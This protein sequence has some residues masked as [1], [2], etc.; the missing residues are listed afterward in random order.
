MDLAALQRGFGLPATPFGLAGCLIQP[1]EQ[2]T[3]GQPS[4]CIDYGSA[5]ALALGGLLQAVPLGVAALPPTAVAPPAVAAASA[6]A[7]A[8]A[9]VPSP[10]LDL[11]LAEAHEAYRAG[12]Y[13]RALALCAPVHAASPCRVDALLLLGAAHYQRGEYAACVAAND[14]AILLDPGLAEAHANLA[15]ALQQLGDMDTAIV[16]YRSALRLKPRFT[17][18]LNNMAS[19]LVAKGLVPAAM[20]AYGAALAI[21]P[22]LVDV[23]NNLGDLWRAQGA[24]GAAAARAR[25][26]EA[27]RLDPGY[28]PAWRGLGDLA[29]E[30]G[31]AAA[32]LGCY[33]E[34]AR[35]R[36]GYADALTGAGVALKELRRRSEAEACFEAAAALRPACA[37][38]LGNLGGMY[39]ERGKLEPAIAAYRRA[40]SLQPLFPEAYNNLGNALREA[41]RVGEAV[42]AYAACIRQQYARAGAP[43][44]PLPGPVAGRL[45]VAYANLG[46]LLKASGQAAPAI[47]CYEQVASLSPESPEAAANLG[48]AYKDAGQHDAAA[49]AYKRALALRPDFPEAFANLVHSLQCVCEWAERG[50]LFARL[51]GDVRRDL[52][53]GRLPAVQPFHA[54]A[55]PFPADLALAISRAYAGQAALAAARLALPPLPHPPAAP[56]ARGQRLRVAYVSADFGNHP[57]SHLM[58][59]VFGLHDRT[60]VEVFCYALSPPDGS[61]WRRRIEA[62]AEHFVDASG[63]GP[64]DIAR[65]ISADG[66]HVALNLN[67]Y[68]RGARNEVFALRPAPVQASYMGFPATTGAPYLPWLITDPVVAPPT[69]RHCYSEALALMP[70][71]YFVNDYARAHGDVLDKSTLPTRAEVGLPPGK[72]VYA[73]SNQLYKFDPDTFATWCR[74]LRRVPDR[75]TNPCPTSR[76]R[77]ANPPGPWP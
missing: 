36:P 75:C 70:H 31:D 44:A 51:E 65:R 15:N 46:G 67:G 10:E 54:M 58:G 76:D 12:D 62:E 21:N 53:G 40:L 38:S 48:S 61:E 26:A 71:C 4:V 13:T 50:P 42:E 17:D 14:A 39:Y 16:Y 55:Y 1:A 68:T 9:P 25:Y 19:A 43:G 66:V 33:G 29:R 37:L 5:H 74:I 20:E 47:A 72:V 45:S 57:L 18:A 24:A 2:Q 35:L 28:A 69:V 3:L 77:L 63:W 11:L 30:A 49:A 6:A 59:S 52:A 56:L 73:C 32:A 7:A 64:A 22:G 23:H 27:L 60:R 8:L 34:A 41:G